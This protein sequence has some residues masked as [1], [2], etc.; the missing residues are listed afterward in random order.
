M[1][2]GDDERV[3]QWVKERI[4]YVINGFGPCVTIGVAR[5]DKLIAGIVYHEWKPAYRSMQVSIAGDGHWCSKRVMRAFYAYPFLQMD[6]V[7]ITAMVAANN[8]RSGDFVLRL[9]F[10][11]EGNIRLGCGE[12]DCLIFGQLKSEATQWIG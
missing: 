7:R 5:E 8:K 3:A 11:F 4:P 12:K 9:G 6:A 1:V 2:Y 10:Q